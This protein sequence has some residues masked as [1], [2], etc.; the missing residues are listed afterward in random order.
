MFQ[1]LGKVNCRP[2]FGS[3]L[4]STLTQELLAMHHERSKLQRIPPTASSGFPN[5]WHRRM[6]I[7]RI[8]PMR[9]FNQIK[10]VLDST[11]RN[12]DLVVAGRFDKADIVQ[13]CQASSEVDTFSRIYEAAR[14]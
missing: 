13:R 14:K 7:F 1:G 12:F 11:K 9:C 5:A 6:L 4:P 3:A 2:F 10:M 8:L